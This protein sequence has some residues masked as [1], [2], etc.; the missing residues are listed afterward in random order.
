VSPTA[1]VSP[2]DNDTNMARED[3]SQVPKSPDRSLFT[4]EDS[5]RIAVVGAK[6]NLKM[7]PF[8]IAATQGDL[9]NSHSRFVGVWSSERGWGNGKG[10]HGM[11]II[12]EVSAT[13]LAR[14]YYL[15]GPPT[16]LSW[17]QA[18]AGYSQFAEHIANNT[19]SFK[20]GEPINA[21][22]DKNN[23]MT[24][25]TFT[26]ERPS[27]KA[28][29]ELNPIWQLAALGHDSTEPS[30]DRGQTSRK[31]KN[32]SMIS[33]SPVGGQQ[34]NVEPS[35]ARSEPAAN[36]RAK[37]SKEA[38]VGDSR[39]NSMRDRLGCLCAVRNGGGISS[40]GKGWYS[41]RGVSEPTNEAFI[42]C[43]IRAGRS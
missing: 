38:P 2:S 33:P 7:P 35:R 15:W 18:P 1:A 28:S 20:S 39:C 30:F 43:Q 40:D 17:N 14:G 3:P 19:F 36:S 12:T 16:K 8:S 6:L 26:P 41:K 32:A 10:R 37:E 34:L 21:K 23:I 4:S 24:L 22:L 29:V 11:L 9:S 13:G 5:Q 42:Q 27:E 25:S 31:A